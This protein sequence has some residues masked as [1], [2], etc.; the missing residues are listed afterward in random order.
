M[1]IWSSSRSLQLGPIWETHRE[2]AG[3]WPRFSSGAH[4]ERAEIVTIFIQKNKSVV[5][6]QREYQKRHRNQSTPDKK[7]IHA[8]SH[9]F[10][11]YGTT[12]DSHHSGR[13]RTA[14]S[15]ENI[16]RVRESAAESP[17]TSIRRR[18][19]QLN[20]SQRSLRR[21]LKKGLHLFPYKIQLVQKLLPR[22]HN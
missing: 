14:R 17:K 13:P 16:A 18:A 8:L 5:L 2:P 10:E 7:T 3:S 19:Q 4:I 6:T 11:Q 22:D 1:S 12:L 20:I 9:Q 15:E 21:I